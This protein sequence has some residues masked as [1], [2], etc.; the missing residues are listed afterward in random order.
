SSSE[1]EP[2][3]ASHWKFRRV[4]SPV[5]VG[6]VADAC[7]H[8]MRSDV[9][10]DALHWTCCCIFQYKARAA[11]TLKKNHISKSSVRV[12]IGRNKGSDQREGG[13]TE[14]NVLMSARMPK[15]SNVSKHSGRMLYRSRLRMDM[16]LL[17]MT[18]FTGSYGEFES[19]VLVKCDCAL[20][21]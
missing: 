19:Q 10:L 13:E 2:Q 12:A 18:K 16:C 4:L 5:P 3:P 6:S 1:L 7:G 15:Q 8:W 21:K 17:K 20:L 9:S 11:V 14:K